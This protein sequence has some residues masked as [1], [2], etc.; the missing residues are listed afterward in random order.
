MVESAPK[1]VIFHVDTDYFYAQVEERENP[2]LKGKP[3]VVCVYSGR[4]DDSGAVSTANYVARKIGVKSGMSIA[5]AKK[6]L[7][8]NK[9]AYF[10]GMRKEYYETVSDSIMDILRNFA[11]KFQ[12]VSIDEA[13]L[14]VT[15]MIKGDFEKAVDLANKIKRD[16]RSREK[17]TCSIGVGPN[18]LIAKMASDVQKPYGLTVVTPE[19]V[20][21]FLNPL[22]VGKLFLV[23]PKTEEKLNEIAVTTI[24]ELTEVKF[25]RLVGD[26]GEK[27]GEYLYRASRGIDN[28]PVLE[29]EI[30]Q[31]SRITTLKRNTRNIKEILPVLHSLAVDVH[32]KVLDEKKDFKSVSTIAIMEDLSIRTKTKGFETVMSSLEVIKNV[33]TEL[34]E[35][36]LNGSQNISV[37]RV[38][39]KVSGLEAKTGQTSL[40]D[41]AK[42]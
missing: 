3:V 34:F 2:L 25:E 42:R 21:S 8:D 7:K 38:G 19:N 31:I 20:Q 9:N 12:Q 36:F 13:F 39:V 16:V 27:F 1:R 14:D 23:G 35:S 28:V 10:V 22:P 29:K 40:I 18:K 11:D 26:F 24:G 32:R 4:T 15:R 6:I 33:S 30:T 5:L 37:R 41:F 17:L